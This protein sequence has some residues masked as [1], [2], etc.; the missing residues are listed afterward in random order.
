ITVQIHHNGT[1]NSS[2]IWFQLRLVGV[3]TI[4]RNQFPTVAINS[5]TNGEFFLG[6]PS[7]TI[8]ARASDE[9]GTVAKVEFFADGVKVGETTNSPPGFNWDNPPVGPHVLTAIAIDDQGGSQE[10]SPVNIVV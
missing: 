5:P 8:E 2:Y 1:G 7:V 4:I 10:S 3:P 9:D 6:P